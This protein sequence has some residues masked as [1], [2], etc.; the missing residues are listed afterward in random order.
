M[1]FVRIKIRVKIT[2]EVISGYLYQ[3]L[4]H[5]I[6]IQDNGMLRTFLRSE[7]TEISRRT[8]QYR[9]CTL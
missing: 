2:G 9:G 8:E 7:I 6:T 5:K 3:T 4:M 1:K